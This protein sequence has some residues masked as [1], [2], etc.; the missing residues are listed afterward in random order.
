MIKE[1]TYNKF[2][3]HIFCP[4]CHREV[5]HGLNF[6]NLKITG[7]IKMNCGTCKK[8]QIVIKGKKME[9]TT[10]KY[11][12]EYIHPKYGQFR[13]TLYLDFDIYKDNTKEGLADDIDVKALKQERID[14]WV[15]S[16]E[17]PPPVV[18]LTKEELQEKIDVI[19]QQIAELEAQKAKL[20]TELALL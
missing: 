18:S 7:T 11:N 8:G 6:G 19:I 13:D 12:F 3:S 2:Q 1:R 10:I 16:I 4:N 5:K 9:E 17:N 15:N 14:A 20:E